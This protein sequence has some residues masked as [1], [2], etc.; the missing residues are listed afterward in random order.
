MVLSMQLNKVESQH[1]SDKTEFNVFVPTQACREEGFAATD[2]QV[3]TVSIGIQICHR[4]CSSRPESC[5]AQTNFEARRC[6]PHDR[7][8]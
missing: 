5:F 8:H 2:A 3:S 6:S 1:R 7:E 4:K